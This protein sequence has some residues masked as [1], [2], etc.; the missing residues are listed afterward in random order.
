MFCGLAETTFA[1]FTYYDVQPYYT[2]G[3]QAAKETLPTR[4][5][6][7]HKEICIE[8]MIEIFYS[9]LNEPLI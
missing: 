3:T 9:F 7:F 2:I 4:F 5:H 8:L 1:D 6:K